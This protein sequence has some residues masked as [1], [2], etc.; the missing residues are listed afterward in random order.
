MRAASGVNGAIG[1]DPNRRLMP[2]TASV[3]ARNAAEIEANEMACS[4][5]SGIRY[6]A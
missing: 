5:I 4:A 1:M 3:A 2:C 6:C